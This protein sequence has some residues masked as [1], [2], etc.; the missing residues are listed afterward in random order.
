MVFVGY[1]MVFIGAIQALS[2]L[3]LIFMADSFTTYSWYD[4]DGKINQIKFHVGFIILMA[5]SK[6]IGGGYLVIR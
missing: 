2:N 5:L 3:M 6:I 4:K 1:L